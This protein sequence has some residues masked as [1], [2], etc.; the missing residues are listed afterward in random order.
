M[1]AAVG[2]F[3]FSSD[4]SAKEWETFFTVVQAEV[5]KI[6][7]CEKV[8]HGRTLM[9][10]NDPSFYNAWIKVMGDILYRLLCAWHID[11]AWWRNLGKVSTI[12]I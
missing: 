10:D 9:T 7:K 12:V 8:I 6:S 11:Q 3:C 1:G 2:T 4:T 5:S